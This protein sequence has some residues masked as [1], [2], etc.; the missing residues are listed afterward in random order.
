[1]TKVVKIIATPQGII[2]VVVLGAFVYYVKYCMD[3]REVEVSESDDIQS[4][5]D[6]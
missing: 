3:K 5:E 1:M 2:F 4:E 6:G